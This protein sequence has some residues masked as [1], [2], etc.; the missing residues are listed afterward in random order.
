[1]ELHIKALLEKVKNR[2][3]EAF[4]LSEAQLK[5]EGAD[6][7]KTCTFIKINGYRMEGGVND[8]GPFFLFQRNPD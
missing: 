6:V 8:D 4:A 5:K 3:F 7:G 2:E 1:M